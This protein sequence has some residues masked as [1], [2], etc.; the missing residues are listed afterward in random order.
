MKRFLIIAAFIVTFAHPVVGQDFTIMFY[1]VEN[2][3]DTEDDTLKD[4]DEFLPGGLRH[5]N[6]YRYHTR[7]N[8]LASVIAASGGWEFPALVGLC[9]IENRGVA[10]DLVYRTSLAGAGYRVIHTDSP[11]RRGIDLALLYRPSVVEVAGYRSLVLRNSQGIPEETRNLLFIKAVIYGD[12]LDLILCHLPSRRG[13]TV[14][15]A[16][17]RE[18]MSL[19][20]RS[21][22]DSV[23]S[24]DE[25]TALVVMGDFNVTPGDEAM[26][27]ISA[28]GL[29]VNMSDAM[30][31]EGF[32]SYR[33][34][35]T[36]EMIDQILVSATMTTDSCRFSASASD[37]RVMINEFLLEPDPRYPGKRP[38]PAYR[39]YRWEGGYSD[40]LPVTMII[41]HR[42]SLLQ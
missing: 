8:N 9:E 12:T 6:G 31:E 25:H 11:D 29:L 21:A 15:S 4:D 36:W 26:R 37:F 2:L 19:M 32:G 14:S 39:G 7:I 38:R 5:W 13:G 23:L 42:E 34:D 18:R 16:P 27:I 20:L 30:A 41:K 40:H 10:E 24:G 28:D 35:G 1:N 33:Y 22:V 17:L 3:F